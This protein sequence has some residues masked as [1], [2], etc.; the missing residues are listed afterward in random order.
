ML[1]CPTLARGNDVSE[2]NDGVASVARP[3]GCARLLAA[4]PGGSGIST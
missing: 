4:V 2:G 3:A 1:Y